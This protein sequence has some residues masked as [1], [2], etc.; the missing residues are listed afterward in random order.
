MLEL[1]NNF[2]KNFCDIDKYE[3]LERHTDSLY[4]AL[5]EE[6]FEDVFL[7]EKR[8]EWHQLPCKVWTDIFT[9]YATVS[10]FPRTCCND[11]KKHDKRVPGLF[12]EEMEVQNFCAC[13]GKILLLRSKE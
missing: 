13:V 12:K 5:S 1:Y 3:E 4:L 7:P 2:F 9:A 10:F 8:A 6:I 11:H